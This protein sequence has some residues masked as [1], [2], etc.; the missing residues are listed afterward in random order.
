MAGLTEIIWSLFGCYRLAL[1]DKDAL[2]F[3]NLSEKGFWAS[4][5]AILLSVPVFAL[6]NGIDLSLV[7]LKVD[8]GTYLLVISIALITSWCCYL[9][10]MAIA[11]RALDLS[12]RFVP[13]VIVYN[14][15]QLALMLVWLPL[16][17]LLLGI[18]GPETMAVFRLLFIG[19]SYVYLWYILVVTLAVPGPTAAALAFL[20]FIIAIFVQMAFQNLIFAPS[21]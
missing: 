1:R 19:L 17:I 15:A 7:D 8:T 4:F 14:W 2:S 3:F 18:M 21:A 9:A 10:A 20:E 6:S 16:S 12:D 11:A 5:T 13:F